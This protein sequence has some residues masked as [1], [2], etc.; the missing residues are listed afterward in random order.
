MD[1]N[2]VPYVVSTIDKLTIQY[3][4]NSSYFGEMD[5]ENN[6]EVWGDNLSEGQIEYS[7]EILEKMKRRF[8]S[9]VVPL[10]RRVFLDASRAKSIFEENFLK[11][12]DF[13][14][15]IQ[16][17]Y[18]EI[19]WGYDKNNPLVYRMYLASSNSYKDFRCRMASNTDIFNYYSSQSYPRFIWVLE[20][21]T[22]STFSEKK[23]RVE[24]LLDATSSI[25]SDT[26]AIL[27]VRYK[28]HLVFVPNVIIRMQ[29]A[30]V[31]E[32]NAYDSK[33]SVNQDY[34]SIDWEQI[35]ENVKQKVLEE[36]FKSLYYNPN[37]FVDDSY[38]IFSNSNLK[39]I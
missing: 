34:S 11:N 3:Y 18:G 25:N 5:D 2:Q 36:I 17:A 7:E 37:N 32:K 30:H 31:F 13:I 39:E 12:P 8:D 26:W 33:G 23:A 6:E 21:G 27:S 9:L 19:S 28:G 22:I 20:I 29:K 1:D 38:E 4:E 16:R 14:K 15:K 24:V 10:Y 35:S